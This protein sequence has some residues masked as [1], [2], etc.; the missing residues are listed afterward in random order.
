MHLIFAGY[1]WVLIHSQEYSGTILD[2]QAQNAHFSII[3][4]IQMRWNL[5]LCWFVDDN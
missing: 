5:N 3:V 1:Q 4:V 2:M